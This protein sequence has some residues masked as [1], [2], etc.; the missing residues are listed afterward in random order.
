MDARY[1]HGYDMQRKPL[2]RFRWSSDLETDSCMECGTIFG[3]IFGRKHHCRFCGRVLC[4]T[5]SDDLINGYRACVPCVTICSQTKYYYVNPEDGIE[6]KQLLT[7]QT[8]PCS[9]LNVK[10]RLQEMGLLGTQYDALAGGVYDV[11]TNMLLWKFEG[12]ELSDLTV[13][14]GEDPSTN[15]GGEVYLSL[16]NGRMLPP[17]Q[18]TKLHSV[19]SYFPVVST[20]THD[21]LKPK[22]LA[23]HTSSPTLD[24]KSTRQSNHNNPAYDF[25]VQAFIREESVYASTLA[26][27]QSEYL[28][29]LKILSESEEPE[30]KHIVQQL[31]SL[32]SNLQTLCTRQLKFKDELEGVAIGEALFR[33]IFYIKCYVAYVNNFHGML[34][35]V[36]ALRSDATFKVLMLVLEG[37][38]KRNKTIQATNLADLLVLP[39][40]R[41][42]QSARTVAELT[43][44]TPSTNMEYKK[45]QQ[46][47]EVMRSVLAVITQN[48]AAMESRMRLVFLH[49]RAS[50]SVD[51][52]KSAGS[53]VREGLLSVAPA[54]DVTVVYLF[55]HQLVY[56]NEFGGY[57]GHFDLKQ[58]Q[59]KGALLQVYPTEV[60]ST[61]DPTL[62]LQLEV[63][64]TDDAAG[65]FLQ[66]SHLK[67][68]NVASQQQQQQQQ[69]KLAVSWDFGAASKT[70]ET[71]LVSAGDTWSLPTNAKVLKFAV[72]VTNGEIFAGKLS[73]TLSDMDNNVLHSVHLTELYISHICNDQTIILPLLEGNSVLFS[74]HRNNTH[75][76]ANASFTVTGNDNHCITFTAADRDDR[77]IWM[78]AI[79]ATLS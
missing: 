14:K 12:L 63:L 20:S 45:L 5:C 77:D 60:K 62:V 39:W 67:V 2:P 70:L 53:L 56:T 65:D 25:L 58:Q 76:A 47:T 10:T 35:A 13:F 55:Q 1:R 72:N 30:T 46:V 29:P 11:T 31:P 74:D 23:K 22:N 71:V 21:S 43:K 48:K 69:L 61:A 59:K 57:D 24:Q 33:F 26:F 41:F 79:L 68:C 64:Q 42:A 17:L 18:I 38:L 7:F 40:K 49:R 51:I 52:S 66:L 73:F 19:P 75:Q 37:K 78:K 28:V 32:L 50:M 44:L 6:Q 8:L 4:S 36:H 15:G 16:S 3:A 9:I 27:V 54:E 34:D